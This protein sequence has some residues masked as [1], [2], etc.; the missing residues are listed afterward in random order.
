LP[1]STGLAAMTHQFSIKPKDNTENNFFLGSEIL[2]SKKN[3]NIG[4]KLHI[5]A[6]GFAII[7]RLLCKW[8]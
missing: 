8:R 6:S 4:E 5:F 7:S 3:S 1:G 2:H